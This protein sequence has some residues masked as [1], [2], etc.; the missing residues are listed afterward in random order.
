M[1][2]LSTLPAPAAPAPVTPA[3]APNASSVP[4]QASSVAPAVVAPAA[5]DAAGAAVPA[6]SEVSAAA[7]A[8]PSVGP[9]DADGTIVVPSGTQAKVQELV[10]SGKA[11]DQIAFI[12]SFPEN[13]RKA[14][15]SIFTNQGDFKFREDDAPAPVVN[16]S[17]PATLADTF[18]PLTEEEYL[19]ADPRLQGY[20]DALV[21]LQEEAKAPSPEYVGLRG[22]VQQL[23]N[24]PVVK[25]RLD[26]LSNG[27]PDIPPTLLSFDQIFPSSAQDPNAP[28]TMESVFNAIYKAKDDPNALARTVHDVVMSAVQAASSKTYNDG[29]AE[30]T[31]RYEEIAQRQ[32]ESQRVTDYWTNSLDKIGHEIQELSSDSPFFQRA[33]DGSLATTQDGKLV[34]NEAHPALP[35]V[36]WLQGQITSGALTD[37]A[38]QKFGLPKM[39]MIFKTEEAGGPAKFIAQQAKSLR[40]MQLQ[41]YRGKRN[42]GLSQMLASTMGSTAQTGS[43]SGNTVHGVDLQKAFTDRSYGEA[44]LRSL[45]PLQRAEVSAAMTKYAA[46]GEI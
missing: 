46:T 29:L 37:A 2:E 15:E 26:A 19:K 38:I 25:T 40:E 17:A 11:A 9:I 34:A 41:N 42:A 10:K 6:A 31:R 14:I 39:Y 33:A 12:N 16:P 43:L 28:V 45:T 4:S 23:L 44:A 7:A 36:K 1:A 32:I 30:G 22:E 5:P 13:Q 3:V 21:A 24:D 8:A 18:V 27:R 35:F 20:H